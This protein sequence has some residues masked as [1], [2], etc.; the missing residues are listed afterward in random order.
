MLLTNPLYRKILESPALEGA[1]T[2]YIV[3]GYASAGMADWH[4]REL[5]SKVT[6]SIKINLIVGMVASDGIAEANHKGLAHLCKAKKFC[7]RFQCSYVT[8]GAPVH[9]K[10]YAWFR[11]QNPIAGFVGSANYTQTAYGKRQVEVATVHDPVELMK[12]Y[13]DVEAR[14]IFCNH[15]DVNGL[16]VPDRERERIKS[17]L[18][19]KPYGVRKISNNGDS[20]TISLLDR[21]GRLPSRSGLNWGQRPEAHREPNQAYI[22][23][24]TGGEMGAK[25]N[26]FFPARGVHFTLHTDDG[27]VMICARRQDTGKA[28][29]ST[30]NNSLIGEYFR[31]RLEVP[32]GELILKDHLIAYNRTKV[33]FIKV[34]EENYF[35]DF[36]A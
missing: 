14:A 20:L 19:R 15:P 7:R 26:S 29:H 28:I 34:D 8:E 31:R 18:G 2:L 33:T 11:Q 13:R 17:H 1:D 10:T 12:F 24:P 32:L 22:R 6:Q 4:L 36:S 23:L 30:E 3:S 25:V 35:M 16:V 21:S 5:D 9:A 27:Q